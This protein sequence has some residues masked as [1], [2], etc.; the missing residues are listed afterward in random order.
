[1]PIKKPTESL[2][3][4]PPVI[5]I[6]GE[7]GTGKTSLAQTFD[8]PLTLDFD[9]GIR[10][11]IGRKDTFQVE[12]WDEVESAQRNGDFKEYNTIVTD[13]I[14]ALLDD[15]LN[16]HV[17]E[18]DY[19][20]QKNKLQ[21]FGAIGDEFKGFLN[22]LRADNK[23]VV[24]IA[25][26]KRD[27]ETKRNQPDITGGSYQLIL[28]VADQIGYLY[29]KNRE[30]WITFDPTEQVVCKNVAQLPDMPVPKPEDPAYRTFGKD[31]ANSVRERLDAMSDEQKEAVEKSNRY[32]QLIAD[33]AGITDLSGIADVILELPS[34]LN[35][36]L[37]Q[38]LG[39]KYSEFI[40]NSAKPEELTMALM[41]VNA[42]PPFLKL[43][44]Q[45]N[46]ANHAKAKGWVANKDTK[47]FEAPDPAKAPGSSAKPQEPTAT[48]Q[49]PAATP[50]F[51]GQS[52][53]K[54]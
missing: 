27:E 51:A 10:R 33:C 3:S 53:P 44:L 9:Q 34:Y 26:N 35:R 21:K 11:A 16:V 14:K 20:L 45:K 49:T 28:R 12:S 5:V 42:L 24:I 13:T 15:Y 41:E 47:A 38:L 18:E 36:P 4:R 43:E 31:L 39:D 40:T 29:Y 46:V 30:R 50:L 17:V 37:I 2:Q 7:Q 48:A 6:Y 25:H 22:V 52:E 1:M 54:A 8:T 23:C 32:Q 19:R